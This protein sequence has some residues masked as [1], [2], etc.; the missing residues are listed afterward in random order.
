MKSDTPILTVAIPTFNRAAKLQKQLERVLSQVTPEVQVSV[1]DNA[2]PDETREIV[3]KFNHPNLSYSRSQNNTGGHH[4]FFRCYEGCQTEWLWIL[5]DDDPITE[6]AIADLLKLIKDCPYEVI[7]TSTPA[8][9]HLSDM[10]IDDI[11]QLNA[12]EFD[13]FGWISGNIYRM[14]VFRPLLW[15]FNTS[16]STPEPHVIIVL[17]LLEKKLGKALLSTTKLIAE[18]FG[19]SPRWSTLDFLNMSC[20]LPAH[21]SYP[22]H[23]ALIAQRVYNNFYTWALVVGKREINDASDVPR[24]KRIRKVVRHTLL[25]YGAQHP[26]LDAFFPYKWDHTRGPK[27]TIRKRLRLLKYSVYY[28]TLVT[29]LAYSPDRCFLPIFRWIPKPRLG[30]EWLFPEDGKDK[31]NVC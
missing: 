5:S 13:T 1:Y 14:P 8:W 24:W 12:H 28:H 2:S 23:Q 4:N 11:S 26:I 22:Q 30:R 19:C 10:V 15:H 18:I 9:R 31:L 21:L 16:M 7:S 6:T 27:K 25:A 20:Q 29:L 17:K 3:E